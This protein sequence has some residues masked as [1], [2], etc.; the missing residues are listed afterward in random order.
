MDHTGDS[1]SKP[2]AVVLGATGA[3]GSEVVKALLASSVFGT[4]TTLGRR[5]LAGLER[6]PERLTQHIVDVFDPAAYE[7]R[8]GGHSAAFCTLGI[9][10]PSKVARPEFYRIDVQCVADFAGACRRRGIS[11]FSLL[12][13][14]GANPR[15]R[16][17]YL[18]M[19]GEVEER[20]AAL[21]FARTSFFRPSMLL[22]P[23]N[24]YG[25]VQAILLAVWPRMDWLFP[26]PLSRFRGIRV[27]ALGSA[28]VR[29]AER[30]VRLAERPVRLAERPGPSVET[31]EWAG[32]RELAG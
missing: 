8:L 10:E 20:V 31:Y 28:M 22:T 32:F 21:G 18:R 4:V 12:T 30:P 13:A 27:E 5:P 11:H 26:G 2:S 29:N 6:V 1:E 16:V 17:H 9:G 3:V 24:R 25:A 23:A 7:A 15:S 14:V 19:K